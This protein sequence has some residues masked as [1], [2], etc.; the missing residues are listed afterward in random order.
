[1]NLDTM[2]AEKKIV[3]LPY[4]YLL[5]VI[6]TLLFSS[7]CKDNTENSFTADFIYESIDSNHIRFTNKSEGEYFSLDWDFA[8]GETASSTDKLET[9]TIYYP[10]Q[11]DYNVKLSVLD[12]TGNIKSI[13]KTVS[14]LKSDL[15][16]S[17]TAQIDAS[18]P[19]FVNLTNTTTGDY[20]SY[21]W[22]YLDKEIDGQDGVVAYFPF[23]GRY[24]VELKVVKGSDSFSQI[25][26]VT[27]SQDDPDYQNNLTLFWA[28]EFDGT[29]VNTTDWTF[30]TG[31]T[32]WGNNELQNYT[33]GDNAKLE[34]GILYLTATKVDNNTAVGSYNS[35]RMITKGKR[36]FTYGRMEIRAKL[37]SGKGIW[38]AIWMLGSNISSIGWPACG[39]IDIMEYVGYEPNTVHATVH[40]LS[41]SGGNGSGSSKT[42]TTAEEEFHIYGLIWTPKELVFYIDSPENITHKYAPSIKNDETW[43][44][45]KPAFFILNV[46]VGG[47]WGGVQGI[48]NT[49]FPQTMEIDYVRVYQ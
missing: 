47:N 35:T 48:D 2:L 44:F 9:F 3:T 32:G 45:S 19:N 37:P 14:I 24:D 36:E 34:N 15:V 12:Y 41:G 27:I 1:M 22:I 38:P 29:A 7:S 4:F 16:L 5:L 46:A 11:G 18:K 13:S 33:N 21:K 23:S 20:D 10:L 28:D 8:N 17:F 42:L 40:T 6:S 31:A 43:P 25:Q 39:E 49:I 30:E 26:S